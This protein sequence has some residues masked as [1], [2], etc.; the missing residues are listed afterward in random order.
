MYYLVYGFFYLLSLLPL[1]I[2]YFISDIGYVLV[3][4]IFK[5]RRNIVDAN[6]LQAFPEKTPAARK[7][8]AKKYYHNLLDSFVETIKS[9]SVG[10]NF[11][12]RHCLADYSIFDRYY[13]EG[14]SCQMHPAHQFNWEWYNHHFAIHM[15]QPSLAVYIPMT[16]PLFDKLFYRQRTKHGSIMLPGV[17]MK[18]SF[19]PWKN[20]I[21]VL[22]LV[23]DQKPGDPYKAYWF[24]FFNKPTPFIKG[25]ERAAREKG[26]PVVFAFCKKIKRGYYSAEFIPVTE[27]AS[28]LPE[29]EL[30]RIY[31]KALT[32]RIKENPDMWLWS[33]NRWKHEWKPEYG[34]LRQ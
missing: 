21:H 7:D 25:P 29:A 31:I 12:S 18:E 11:Y 20:K 14:K 33:H 19:S 10:K 15:K 22:T 6:L 34:E 8:I 24:N 1:K 5:Y 9:F 23:A 17:N 3:Y 4:Y 26:C 32:E 2:L 16:N 13:Q 27:D 30:T 28:Q